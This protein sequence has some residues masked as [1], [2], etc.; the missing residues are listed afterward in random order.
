MEVKACL[1]TKIHTVKYAARA[2]WLTYHAN[3]PLAKTPYIT[4]TSLYKSQSAVKKAPSSHKKDQQEVIFRTIN[5]TANI[6]SPTC[7]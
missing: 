7:N 6:A 2:S 3:L 4:A 5:E 1:M